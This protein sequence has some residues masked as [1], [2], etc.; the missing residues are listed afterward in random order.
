MCLSAATAPLA[1][2]LYQAIPTSET[3]L[4]IPCAS[5]DRAIRFR[6]FLPIN[7]SPPPFDVLCDAI[8]TALTNDPITPTATIA[9]LISSPQDCSRIAY[10]IV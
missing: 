3:S 7:G 2:D 1:S 6:F 8:N 9:S 4:Y 5:G 10:D